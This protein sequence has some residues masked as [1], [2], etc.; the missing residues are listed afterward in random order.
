MFEFDFHAF[1]QSLQRVSHQFR[2]HTFSEQVDG[3][4]RLRQCPLDRHVCA[5]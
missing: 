4:A 2:A 3:L 1:V 5:K